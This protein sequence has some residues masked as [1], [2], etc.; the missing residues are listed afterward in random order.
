MKKDCKTFEEAM[1]ELEEIVQKL[2]KGELSL[3]ESIEYFQRGVELSRYCSKKLD[4]VERRITMLIEEEKGNIK[5]EIFEVKDGG[6]D[7]A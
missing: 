3:E 6:N 5:E 7:E 1:N 2:E 4:E